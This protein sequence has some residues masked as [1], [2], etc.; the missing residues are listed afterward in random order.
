M[1]NVTVQ[2]C[3]FPHPYTMTVKPSDTIFFQQDGAPCHYASNVRRLLND[4]FPGKWIGRAGPIAWPRRSPDL[5]PMDY[6]LR[7]QV[8]TVV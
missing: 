1:V 5:T 8:K 2:C 4:V 7:G 6:F 3:R